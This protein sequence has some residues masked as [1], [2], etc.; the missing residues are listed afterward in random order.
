MK[1]KHKKQ[2]FLKWIFDGF[3][4][5][6]EKKNQSNPKRNDG[7]TFEEIQFFDMMDD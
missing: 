3:K 4:K 6:F 7:L 2:G 5:I 1:K